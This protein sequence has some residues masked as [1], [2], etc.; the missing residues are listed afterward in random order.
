MW[1][2]LDT[3]S[4]IQ[5]SSSQSVGCHTLTGTRL[6]NFVFFLNCKP[7]STTVQRPLNDILVS[8]LDTTSDASLLE[9]L[10]NE[11]CLTVVNVCDHGSTSQ[12]QRARGVLLA[13]EAPASQTR[14]P[15]AAR[16][17][18]FRRRISRDVGLHFSDLVAACRRTTACSLAARIPAFVTTSFIT[19]MSGQGAIRVWFKCSRVLVMSSPSR[20]QAQISVHHSKETMTSKPL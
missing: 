19:P 7:F 13:I 11:V 3:R 9:Q 10:V 1:E 5:S 18:V 14:W 20:A 4:P 2:L 16:I 6:N 17:P 15:E 8:S 12:G